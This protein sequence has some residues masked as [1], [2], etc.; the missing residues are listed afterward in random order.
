ML[1]REICGRMV[2][3]SI[4][5]DVVKFQNAYE[6]GIYLHQ[7]TGRL[8]SSGTLPGYSWRMPRTGPP[9]LSDRDSVRDAS[10][11]ASFD[12]DSKSSRS[13]ANASDSRGEDTRQRIVIAVWDVLA[14]KGYAG[15]TVRLRWSD[16]R[17]VA[18]DDSLLLFQQG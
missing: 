16:G 9:K 1:N 3:Y 8:V 4:S 5:M 18:R 2:S 13:T 6:I 17:R 10:R 14:D 15:L 11:G 12:S 7:V